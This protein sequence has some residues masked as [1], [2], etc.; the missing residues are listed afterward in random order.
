MKPVKVEEHLK[1]KLKDPYFRALHQVEIQ[2]L[3]IVKPI[4]AYRIKHKLSQKQLAKKAGVTQQHISKIE[5]GEFS[6][7]VTLGKI[8]LLI[9]YTVKLDIVPLNRSVRRGIEKKIRSAA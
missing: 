8:L 2:K 1:K 3:S 7:L 4:V 6:N 5:C 9:G